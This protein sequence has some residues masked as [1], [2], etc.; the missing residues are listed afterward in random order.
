MPF[1]FWTSIFGENSVTVASSSC[2]TDGLIIIFDLHT[3]MTEHK[4]KEM[5][6]NQINK[7]GLPFNY[8]GYSDYQILSKN[9]KETAAN[10]L[11]S[12]TTMPQII[13]KPIENLR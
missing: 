3:N 13:S 2:D 9:I 12:E 1:P 5:L 11:Q 6:D 4:L 7:I 10:M 8:D